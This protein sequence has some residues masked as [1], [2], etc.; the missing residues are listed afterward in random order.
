MSGGRIARDPPPQ[1]EMDYRIERGKEAAKKKKKKIVS[2]GE[3]IQWIV[4]LNLLQAE[5][6]KSQRERLI[7]F[8]LKLLFIKTY[9]KS[10]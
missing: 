10:S 7:H 1:G 9:S 2:T 4:A 6:K 3:P 8:N 5:K